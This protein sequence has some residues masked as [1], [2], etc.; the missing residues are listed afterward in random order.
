MRASLIF[1]NLCSAL[2][3]AH[4]HGARARAR[5]ASAR[6]ATR[7]KWRRHGINGINQAY[8][9]RRKRKYNQKANIDAAWRKLG[10]APSVSGK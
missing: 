7:V 6:S 2:F 9:Q 5:R 3:A 10:M 8:R 1:H 4:A